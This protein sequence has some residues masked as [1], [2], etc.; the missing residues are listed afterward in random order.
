MGRG[1]LDATATHQDHSAVTAATRK[2][3]GPSG[4]TFVFPWHGDELATI[5]FLS[6][7][8]RTLQTI[9]DQSLRPRL[10]GRRQNPAPRLKC[11][12]LIYNDIFYNL[13]QQK[14]KSPDLSVPG[15]LN[16]WSAWRDSNSRPLAPHASALPGCATRRQDLDCISK[17]RPEKEVSEFLPIL[18]AAPQ[19]SGRA[20]P[21]AHRP[22]PPAAAPAAR[23][24]GRP[25]CAR[26]PAPAGGCARR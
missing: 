22:R 20:A 8:C 9:P 5:K 11:K 25:P 19:H 17:I 15:F 24:R 16:K 23:C 21:P 26:A 18:C 13:R 7:T 4:R 12:L 1:S 3:L 6:H 14:E 2:S 10:F